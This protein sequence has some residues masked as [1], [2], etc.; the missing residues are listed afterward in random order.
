MHF[1]MQ[2]CLTFENSIRFHSPSSVFRLRS[3]TVVSVVSV[4]VRV[5]PSPP[6]PPPF[7]QMNS[8][9][10]IV[11]VKNFL[12]IPLRLPFPLRS[13]LGLSGTGR[14]RLQTGFLPR[15]HTGQPLKRAFVCKFFVK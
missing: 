12:A 7:C 1:F 13:V 3:S 10:L 5:F 15:S 2:F 6:A 14:A 8:L 11:S 4:V 9:I